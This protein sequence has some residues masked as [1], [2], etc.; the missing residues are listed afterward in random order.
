MIREIICINCP[1]GCHLQVDETTLSVTGNQ[2]VKGKTY[3]IE[4]V[5]NPVR[6]VTSTCRVEGGTIP[7]VSCKTNHPIPKGSI[8]EVMREINQVRV[9]APVQLGQVLIEN[10]LGTGSNIVATK[11]VPRK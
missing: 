9:N 4:E 2:C 3:G 6:T 7:R 5:T 8:F 1:R 10:V 11:S